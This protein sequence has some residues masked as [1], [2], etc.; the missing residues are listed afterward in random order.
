MVEKRSSDRR[1]QLAAA[2]RLQII[3][4][5]AQL[6]AEKGFHRTTTRDIAE[7]A[8]VSEGTLYNYFESKDELLLGIMEKLSDL[9]VMGGRREDAVLEDPHEFFVDMM[10]QRRSLIDENNAMLQSVLSEILVNPELCQRYY[11][12]LIIPAMD[13]LSSHMQ[14]LVD[15]GQLRTISAAYMARVLMG[16]MMGLFVLELL[17]DSMIQLE[18][19]DL[20]Q[21]VALLFFEGAAPVT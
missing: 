2:R 10:R 1:E 16:L 8:E 21:F 11:E 18:W 12:E 17:G 19:E 9:P 7:A 4:A 13:I 3:E 6:F 14:T 15:Q 20:S 5:A